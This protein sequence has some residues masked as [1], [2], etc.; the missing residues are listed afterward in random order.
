MIPIDDLFI[1]FVIQY[2]TTVQLTPSKLFVLSCPIFTSCLEIS[3]LLKRGVKLKDQNNIFFFLLWWV[4]RMSTNQYNILSSW[5]DIFDMTRWWQ[6]EAFSIWWKQILFK[7]TT[8]TLHIILYPS[9]ISLC[10][11]Y[12]VHKILLCPYA[13]LIVSKQLINFKKGI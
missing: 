4:I 5:W 10:T 2:T 11:V 13:L 9:H 6:V 7:N 3:L 1:H 8:T 12:I